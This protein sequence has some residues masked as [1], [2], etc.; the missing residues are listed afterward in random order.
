MAYQALYRKWRPATF[1]DV[2]GQGHVVSTLKNQIATGKT[3]HAYLFCG[4]RGTGKTSCAKIF[5]RAINC[6][7]P[8]SGNPCNAC[9]MCKGVAS[10]SILDITEIDAASNNGV[11]NIRDIRDEVAYCAA[12]A[13]YRIYIIDEVH[14]LSTGAFNALLKTLEEPPAYVVFILATTEAHKLPAT[15]TS[16]CQRFDFKRIG[17]N[18]IVLRLR[19]ITT[20]EGINASPDALETIARLAD[21][22]MRDA[23]SILDQCVSACPDV[24]TQQDI[25]AVLGIAPDEIMDNTVV[26]I[27]DRDTPAVL[28][29]ITTLVS[30]GRDLSNFIDMLIGRFRD[31]MVCKATG[32]A[33][34]LFEYSTQN[35][36]SILLA[37]NR[38]QTDTV[39][40]IIKVLCEAAS[41]AKWSKNARVIYELALM[42]LC[43]SR[44]D[45]SPESLADR[46]TRLEAALAQGGVPNLQPPT[47]STA[48]ADPLSVSASADSDLP[49]WEAPPETHKDVIPSD[50]ADKQDEPALHNPARQKPAKPVPA[51]AGKTQ[52]K[53]SA[54]PTWQDVLDAMKKSNAA[55]YG[56]LCAQKAKLEGNRLLFPN[57]DYLKNIINIS[58]KSIEDVLKSVTG[59]NCRIVFV[60]EQELAD[61]NICDTAGAG[62]ACA[63]ARDAHNALPDTQQKTAGDP[64]PAP[65]PLDEL[66][67]IDGLNINIE[68]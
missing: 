67:G 9:E 51:S 52:N 45:T 60:A 36:D 49:L 2:V 61:A 53:P 43:D 31:I 58:H 12:S 1:D 65:D 48:G 64:D 59:S 54:S 63:P 68:D 55:L 26:A 16:R 10:G 32:G 18:D 6:L 23:L 57:I 3:A 50:K 13:K 27:A 38:F 4:T 39:S 25:K 28:N 11:D 14:M 5:A 21:G 20:A 46:I 41:E 66:M 37:S 40:Y 56:M 47:N 22:A 15:I 8:Q 24:M 44:L 17:V 42:K 29:M 62:G 7:N 35:A 19:E 34:D 30:S 33:V